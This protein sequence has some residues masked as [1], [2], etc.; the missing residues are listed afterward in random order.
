[1]IS[2]FKSCG[3]P[4]GLLAC[5]SN[6]QTHLQAPFKLAQIP[7]MREGEKEKKERSLHSIALGGEYQL[8][9]GG[10]GALITTGDQ[11]LVRLSLSLVGSFADQARVCGYRTL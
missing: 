3:A 2:S 9:S 4:G 8:S 11:L 6:P 1:M 10:W 5:I 7:P